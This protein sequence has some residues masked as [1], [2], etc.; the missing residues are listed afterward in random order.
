MKRQIDP[1]A[2]LGK[3]PVCST[4]TSGHSDP[5][6]PLPRQV[7]KTHVKE[8]SSSSANLKLTKDEKPSIESMY[9]A[10]VEEW[11]PP[12]I[13]AEREDPDEQEWLFG[14]KPQK[15]PGR[16]KAETSSDAPC[17]AGGCH[18]WPRAHYLP[19]VEIFALPYTVPF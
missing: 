2:P 4:S 8:P 13:L 18:L 15:A 10:L 1:E 7:S 12:P 3:E 5:L 16:L 9:K 14:A 17:P 6:V 19:D 11:S